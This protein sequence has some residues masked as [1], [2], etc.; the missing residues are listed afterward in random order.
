MSSQPPK[1]TVKME[2]LPARGT[3]PDEKAVES[4]D[5]GLKSRKKDL[6][7][8]S[9]PDKS[10]VMVEDSPDERSVEDGGQTD[11]SKASKCSKFQTLVLGFVHKFF[12]SWVSM[13]IAP[14]M[15]PRDFSHKSDMQGKLVGR[16]P[17]VFIILTLV[18][19]GACSS[20]LAMSVSVL[21]LNTEFALFN[22][23]FVFR[24]FGTKS[25]SKEEDL[26]R[27]AFIDLPKEVKTHILL[28]CMP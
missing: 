21:F 13:Y 22:I 10:A 4:K 9:Q 11:L 20:G 24:D 19:T 23:T 1:R 5:G 17:V 16:Y 8:A 25:D 3:D 27:L 6:S 15:L 26:N 28:L 7:E 14:L 2:N 12:M 18:V